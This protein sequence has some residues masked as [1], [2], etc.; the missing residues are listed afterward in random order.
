[1]GEAGASGDQASGALDELD[2]LAANLAAP[3][4]SVLPALDD[5]SAIDELAFVLAT[6][7]L[8]LLEKISLLEQWRY[9]MLLRDVAA[10]EGLSEGRD[11]GALLQQVSKALLYLAAGQCRH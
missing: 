8:S 10:S 2:A 3:A 6:E 1:M 7:H 9:D 4:L 5:E 11:S